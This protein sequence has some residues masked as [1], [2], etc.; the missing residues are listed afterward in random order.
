M[1]TKKNKKR[2]RI[3]TPLTKELEIHHEKGHKL[4]P[5]LYNSKFANNDNDFIIPNILF[6]PK[7]NLFFKVELKS[8]KGFP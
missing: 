5:V 6:C 4:L 7:C 3:N 1:K 2:K 8:M